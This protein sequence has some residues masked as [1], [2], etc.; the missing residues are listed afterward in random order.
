MAST[1]TQR[2]ATAANVRALLARHR[3]TQIDLA[4]LLGYSQ[5]TVSRRVTGEVPF[6]VDELAIIAARFEVPVESLV[7]AGAA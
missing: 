6:D 2:E 7:A 3:W 4:H 5:T 1:T